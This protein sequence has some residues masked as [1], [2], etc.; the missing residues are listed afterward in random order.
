MQLL[1]GLY[2]RK[3]FCSVKTVFYSSCMNDG[4]FINCYPGCFK[5]RKG[6]KQKVKVIF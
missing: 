1:N 5:S 4:E 3:A 6:N 2:D